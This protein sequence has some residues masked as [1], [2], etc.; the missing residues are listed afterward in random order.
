MIPVWVLRPLVHRSPYLTVWM[1]VEHTVQY[2]CKFS[3]RQEP[4]AFTSHG[5]FLSHVSLIHS[6]MA[7]LLCNSSCIYISSFC[8]ISWS[9][10]SEKLCIIAI[11]AMALAPA[12]SGTLKFAVGKKIIDKC[13]CSRCNIMTERWNISYGYIFCMCY[14]L[15]DFPSVQLMTI[16]LICIFI[17]LL[18]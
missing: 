11:T 12:L 7:C 16:L 10:N 2:M 5:T 13:L 15:K 1:L 14:H 8:L 6:Y 4:F 18:F 17:F 3:L 9:V